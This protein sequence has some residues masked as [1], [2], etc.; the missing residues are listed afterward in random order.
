M[1][2]RSQTIETPINHYA[3]YHPAETVQGVQFIKEAIISQ[4]VRG[5]L[6][7]H[8]QLIGEQPNDNLKSQLKELTTK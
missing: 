3:K 7:T 2:L 4:D 8:C 5:E 1:R 6:K